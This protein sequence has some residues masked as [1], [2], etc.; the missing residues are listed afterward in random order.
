ME[1]PIALFDLDNTLLGGDSDYLW[2]QFLAE[3]GIVDAQWYETTNRQFY[4]DYRKGC[5]DITAFLEFALQPLSYFPMEQLHAWREQ[6][7]REKIEP[8]LLPAAQS[9]V[10]S[11]RQQGDLLVIITAT[12]AFV[13]EP[14]AGLFGIEHLIATEP[15]QQ[16]G[17]YTGRFVGT[18][19]FQ[20]GKVQRL[21]A[22]LDR[23]RMTLDNSCFYS[24][25][26]NDLPLLEKVRHPVAV[27]PDPEL[28]RI[29]ND[30]NW[31]IL[32]LR[33]NA[34]PITLL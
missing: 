7:V 28:K 29:A 25:S 14:I 21:E 12:N 22:W 8:I 1:R 34:K 10:E 32:T 15:E 30:R 11:H 16:E 2:G 27:D 9:L 13:T 26:R 24:D 20:H 18:P 3:Q 4:E 19:C 17:R 33:A 5:L 6:F 23:R 31:P